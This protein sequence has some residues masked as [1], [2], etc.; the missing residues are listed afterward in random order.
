MSSCLISFSLTSRLRVFAVLFLFAINGC[1]PGKEPDAIWLETGTGPGY[2]VY[3]RAI[4]YDP[5]SDTFY[6]VDRVAHVQ[7]LDNTGKCLAD[8][9]MPE[10]KIGKPVGLSVGPDGNVYVPDTHYQRIIVYSPDGKE[11]RR[12]GSSGTGQGQFVYPTD[13]AFDDTGKVFVSEYGDHD[14]IQVFDMQGKYLYEFGSF[15]DGDGQFRRPQSMVIR[16]DRLWVTDACNHRIVVFK[17]DGTF[18]KNIGD[19]GTGP[20]Q[21]RFPYGL[22]MDAKG[23][24]VVTEFGNCRVQL[25]DAETGQQ[26]GVWGTAGRERGELAYP[27]AAVVDKKGRVVTVDAGNN[28]LQLFRF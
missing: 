1:G 4:T 26:K 5:A 22:D 2:V 15:G 20:G 9:T 23:R 17:T 10:Q 8:W 3:P 14:R 11:V 21:F 16:G 27:W 24:L 6:V 28:R 13:I 18:V 7:R 19:V 25:I 12:W